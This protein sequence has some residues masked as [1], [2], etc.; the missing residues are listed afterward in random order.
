MSS[1]TTQVHQ[2]MLSAE[3]CMKEE[4]YAEAFFHWTKAIRMEMPGDATLTTKMYAQRAKCFIQTEQFYYAYEDAKHVLQLDPEYALGHLRMAE[5]YYETGHFSEALPV[6]GQCFA[7]TP[8]KAEKEYLMEWQRK[9]RRDAAKQKMKDEQLPYVGAAIGIV[10]ASLGVVADALAYG[11]S[12]FIAHPVLKALV[13]M[14]MAGSCFLMAVL[15]RRSSVSN[16]KAL[17]MPPPD[18]FGAGSSTAGTQ[19]NGSPRPKED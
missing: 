14:I 17:L 10:I 13:V 8:G 2:V 3:K 6:I 15:I 7:L 11:S 16:R 9:C 18:L 12:S 4:K 1:T 5:V 19:L